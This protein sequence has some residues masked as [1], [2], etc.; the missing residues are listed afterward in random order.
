M[1]CHRGLPTLWLEILFD[2]HPRI[3]HVAVGAGDVGVPMDAVPAVDLK[4]RVPGE[5]QLEA[6]DVLLPLQIGGVALDDLDDVLDG[7]VAHL[8]ALPG[9]EDVDGLHLLVFFDDIGH[10]ALGA[11]QA[12]FLLAGG[13]GR[14]FADVLQG[15][16]QGPA[17]ELQVHGLVVVA[18]DAH[19][20]HALELLRNLGVHFHVRVFEIVLP[21]FLLELGGKGG[22]AGEADAAGL[23]AGRVDLQLVDE[24]VVMAPDFVVLHP[25]APAVEEQGHVRV[26]AQLVEFAVAGPAPA[27]FAQARRGWALCSSARSRIPGDRPCPTP[28]DRIRRRGWSRSSP[29]RTW[30][31]NRRSTRPLPQPTPPGSE[32]NWSVRFMPSSILIVK[33]SRSR[34]RRCCDGTCAG[35]TPSTAG[36]H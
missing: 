15:L 7:D 22:L 5:A 14:V 17:G 27:V 19:H 36:L 29:A 33:G 3:L 6:G 10:V 23:Q 12:A 18:V 28:R 30:G 24:H 11:H 21:H 8:A 16:V 32:N 25:E 2:P 13:R 9:E 1:P 35:G 4:F 26:F 31:A 34:W 20:P